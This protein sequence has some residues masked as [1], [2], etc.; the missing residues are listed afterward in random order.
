MKS[1]FKN[2]CALGLII[3]VVILS[4]AT[5]IINATKTRV[6]FVEN[7]AEVILTPIQKMFNGIEGGFAKVSEYFANITDLT[8]K[9][10]SLAE[11]NQKLK[12]ELIEIETDRA[13]N[14]ELRR[15]L[16]LKNGSPEFEMECAEIVARDTSNWFNTFTIDKGSKDGIAVNQPVITVGKALVGRVSQV[17]STWAHIVTI[18]DPEHSAGSEILR[19]GDFGITDGESTLSAQG[20]CK[21][22]FISKNSNVVP[23]DTVIT[24]G[25]GGIYP[26]GLSIGK[27]IEICPDTQG[28]SQY[29]VLK[30]EA[31]LDSIRTVFII[32][33]YSA[34]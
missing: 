9:N 34:E 8:E 25:L 20:K 17:G 26:K 2:R 16:A 18:T 19:S 6:T 27:V 11:E 4:I 15:M 22:S 28:I 23:G 32:K 21:L 13:E 3:I 29:A 33:N 31:E 10:K 14:E 5:G 24:S 1:F 30:P 12:A 7:I